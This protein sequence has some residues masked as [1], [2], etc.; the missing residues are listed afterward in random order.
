MFAL[1]LSWHGLSLPN[2]PDRTS[3][4]LD[5]HKCESPGSL[6]V[7]TREQSHRQAAGKPGAQGMLSILFLYYSSII[8]L[9]FLYC[10]SIVPLLFIVFSGG[11]L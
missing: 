3:V 2:R 10:S 6:A 5:R 7:R 11:A 1:V 8:P 4:A 9:L